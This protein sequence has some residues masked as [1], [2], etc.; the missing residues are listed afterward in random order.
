M[1]VWSI[2]C[3]KKCVNIFCMC[4]V[5]E[6]KCTGRVRA[7]VQRVWRSAVTLTSEL[8]EDNMQ[9]RFTLQLCKSKQ[10]MRVQK[11]VSKNHKKNCTHMLAPKKSHQQ[12]KFLHTQYMNSG[13]EVRM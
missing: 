5:K 3:E 11:E 13:A 8:G 4:F 2:K 10:V 9:A 7:A 6:K 12:Q 1:D